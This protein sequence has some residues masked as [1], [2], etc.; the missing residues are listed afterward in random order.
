MKHD[1]NEKETAESV[2]RG[3]W[4]SR[5]GAEREVSRY[6]RYAKATFRKVRRLNIRISSKISKPSRRGRSKRDCRIRRSSRACSTST[7]LDV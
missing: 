4:R 6:V 7:R 3:E 1:A 2:E 5:K